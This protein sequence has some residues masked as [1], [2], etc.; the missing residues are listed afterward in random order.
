MWAVRTHSGLNLTVK[1]SSSSSSYITHIRKD[2]QPD[3]LCS[4]LTSS[5]CCCSA[6]TLTYISLHLLT[7]SIFHLQKLVMHLLPDV[8][9]SP[10]TLDGLGSPPLLLL[11]YVILK[12]TRLCW[13]PKRE[14]LHWQIS[15]PQWYSLLEVYSTSKS[16]SVSQSSPSAA[17]FMLTLWPTTDFHIWGNK[18]LWATHDNLHHNCKY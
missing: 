5:S 6:P 12:H 4:A 7:S 13:N 8:L 18:T 1:V 14:F 10:R 3:S 9:F 11:W 17:T 2:L 15:S 16:G